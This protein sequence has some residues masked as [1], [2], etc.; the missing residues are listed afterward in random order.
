MT[1]QQ[2]EYVIAVAEECSFSKAAKRLFIAQPSLSQYI[3]N[4][5]ESVG[6]QLFDRSTSPI[7][8]TYAGKTYVEYA[9]KILDMKEQLDAKMEDI[10]KLKE[11]YL[12]IGLSTFRTFY[13]MPKALKVFQDKYPGIRIELVEGPRAYLEDECLKGNIDIFIT[14]LPGNET[15]FAYEVLMEEKILLAVPKDYKINKDLKTEGLI[16][17]DGFPKVNLCKFKNEPFVL[18]R[19]EQNLHR[20]AIRLCKRAGFKPN[21]SIENGGMDSALTMV[22]GGVGITF[23]SDNIS[24][25]D[26]LMKSLVYYKLDDGEAKREIA[27]VYKKNRNLSQV[28]VEL[29][30][31]IKSVI[32]N[33]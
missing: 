7:Q 2:L 13:F 8:L 6:V 30:D 33:K 27:V 19:P 1:F 20:L 17:E 5:E 14:T 10:S 25:D 26:S 23:V 28:G 31:I 11:G 12:K 18:L 24:R 22:L 21:I 16:Y 3:K 29:I 9:R 32:K 15:Y 4:I